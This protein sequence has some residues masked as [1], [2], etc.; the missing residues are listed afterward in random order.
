MYL[1]LPSSMCREAGSFLCLRGALSSAISAA[2]KPSG[3]VSS[4]MLACQAMFHAESR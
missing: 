1:G 4:H 3:G 2:V